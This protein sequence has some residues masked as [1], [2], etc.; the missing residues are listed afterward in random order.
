MSVSAVV[1][2]TAL[3]GLAATPAMAGA[4][5]AG[6]SGTY[7]LHTGSLQPDSSTNDLRPGSSLE[8]T[9]SGFVPG[10]TVQLSIRSQA[11]S[12]GSVKT[13]ASGSFTWT[14]VLPA[15]LAPGTH[16]LYAVGPDPRGGTLEETLTIV[17]GSGGRVLAHTGADAAPVAATTGTDP[18]SWAAIGLG[19]CA[20]TGTAVLATK[21]RRRKHG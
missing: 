20:L 10:S 2:A 1:A 7:P 16:V 5:S 18:A 17:V 11:I 3:L 8:V 13:D 9:G 6:G 4:V 14:V 12:L 19:A 15:G 21:A